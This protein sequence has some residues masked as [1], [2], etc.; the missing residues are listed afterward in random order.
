MVADEY[1]MAGMTADPKT[2]LLLALLIA[3]GCTSSG[4]PS[5]TATA[6]APPRV[7]CL[8]D[9]AAGAPTGTAYSRPLIFLF[10]IQSP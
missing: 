8:D 6:S 7:R 9:P 10:C 5:S 2:W 3:G 4:S 1:R